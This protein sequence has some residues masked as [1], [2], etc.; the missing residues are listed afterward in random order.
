VL[1][2]SLRLRKKQGPTLPSRLVGAAE[3]GLL[4]LLVSLLDALLDNL[5]IKLPLLPGGTIGV[6]LVLVPVA[7]A[8][9]L[10]L[11]VSSGS[12]SAIGLVL[13]TQLRPR[14]M[15][16]ALWVKIESGS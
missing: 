12:A 7:L 14:E 3:D 4:L 11:L 10:L 1:L 16:L 6:V 5:R 8:D 9:T 13:L 2:L 15:L